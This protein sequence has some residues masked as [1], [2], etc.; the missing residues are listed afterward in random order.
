MRAIKVLK[1][2]YALLPRRSID[3]KV[4]QTFSPCETNARAP[5]TITAAAGALD[6]P[7]PG[8]PGHPAHPGHPDSDKDRGGQAPAQRWRRRFFSFVNRF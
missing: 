6:V 3:I 7:H 2:L 1:D 8:H 4:F 5:H